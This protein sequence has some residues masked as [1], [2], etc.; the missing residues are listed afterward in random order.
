MRTNTPSE[1]VIVG[2]TANRRSG[3]VQ[4]TPRRCFKAVLVVVYCR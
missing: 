4:T 1:A 3:S 2:L